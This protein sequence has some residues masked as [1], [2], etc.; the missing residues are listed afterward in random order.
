MTIE[1]QSIGIRD[2]ADNTSAI[3]AALPETGPRI[4]TKHGVPVAQIIPISPEDVEAG[5]DL[6]VRSA[7]ERVPA[8]EHIAGLAI[9]GPNQAPDNTQY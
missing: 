8:L 3:I 1:K 9:D 5:H 6:M 4:I 7:L 2:L